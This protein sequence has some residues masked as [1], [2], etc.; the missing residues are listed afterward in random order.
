MLL[1]LG[2]QELGEAVEGVVDSFTHS[3]LEHGVAISY[4]WK[5]V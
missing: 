2:L 3:V 4:D 1:A 5:T